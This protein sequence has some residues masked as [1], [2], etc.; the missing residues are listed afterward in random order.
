MVAFPDGA[1]AKGW[2]VSLSRAS[3]RDACLHVQQDSVAS[4]GYAAWGAQVSVGTSSRRARVEGPI[5]RSNNA[6]SLGDASIANGPGDGNGTLDP[7]AS[8]QKKRVQARRLTSDAVEDRQGGKRHK[9][10]REQDPDV[11]PSAVRG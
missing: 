7:T 2:Y 6:Q 4:I 10:R 8:E 5:E 11:G 1:D 9:G 3:P